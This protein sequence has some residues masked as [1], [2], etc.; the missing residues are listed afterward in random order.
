M[1]IVFVENHHQPSI[2]FFIISG[3]DARATVLLNVTTHILDT[4]PVF[5]VQH[6]NM[7]LV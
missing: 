3:G 7:S 1:A 2:V 5:V 4:S 6:F